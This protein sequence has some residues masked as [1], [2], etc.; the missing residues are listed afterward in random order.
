MGYNEYMEKAT[1]A[2]GCFWCTEAIFKRLRGVETVVSGYSGG[3]TEN[4]T[5]DDVSSG[6][7]GH[8]ECIQVTFDPSVISYESLLDV[9][10]A[11]HDPTTPNRQGND[12][13]TQYRSAIFYHTD[14]QKEQ[15]LAAKEKLG[16]S[17]KYQD[18]VVTQIVE[19]TNFYPAEEHHKDYYDSNRS[20]PYCMFVIDPK[21]RKLMEH[22]KEEVKEEYK[23]N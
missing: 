18:P 11:T 23:E 13:G 4:P 7:T 3:E 20:A 14:E 2:S 19:F 21:I 16:Q 8:A 17:G 15:A 10:F 6:T 9:F 5:Y 1:F 12:V 22:F